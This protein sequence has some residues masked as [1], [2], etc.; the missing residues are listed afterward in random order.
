MT[1]LLETA[2]RFAAAGFSV[3]PA[4]A[5]G[6]KAPAA[7]W[8]PFQ[9]RRAAP[10][11]L[12]DWLSSGEH[13]GIGVVTG[14]VSGGLE[15]LEFEGRAVRE[16]FVQRLADAFED[17]GLGDLWRRLVNG[18]LE[19]TPSNGLHIL[20]RVDGELRGNTKLARRPARDDELT[21]QELATRER[22][23]G[24]QFARVLIE[25]RGEGGY[26]VTAPSA[27]RTHPSGGAW[28][29]LA[30]GPE[31]VAAISEDERDAVHAI[32]S[33]LD[34]MPAPVAPPAPERPSTP[35]SGPQ[36]GEGKRPGDDFNERADWREI[37]APHGWMAITSYGRGLAWRRPGKDRGISAT[38][39]T[40]EGDNLFVFSSSTEFEPETP[41][42]K[43]GAYALL[44]H[45]GD[46]AAAARELAR[47]GYG[48]PMPRED[49]DIVTLIAD[50]R[51]AVHGPFTADNPR[52][53]AVGGTEGNLATVHELEPRAR[54]QAVEEST[55]QHSD[56]RNAL[57]L[58]DRFGEQIR[59]C[60]DRGRWLVWDETRWK[61]CESGGGV[62]REF[63]RRIARSLPTESKEQARFKQ[64]SLSARGIGSAVI[65]AQTDDRVTIPIGDLDARPFDL[66]TPGGIIDLRTGE[67]RDC[68]PEGLHTR[69]AAV[70]PDFDMATPRW[71]RFLDD[72]FGGDAQMIAFVQRL[73]GYSASADVRHHILPFPHGGGQNGK[74]VLMDTL[75]H[76]L[77][78]YAT[79][80]PPGF[81]M[82]GKHEHSAEVARLQGVRLVVASEVNQNSRFDEAKLKELTGGD[83]LTARFMRQDFFTFEPTHHLWLMAN[84]KPQVRA[85]GD[86]FWRRLR[87]IPFPNRVPEDKKIEGLTEI[88]CSEE[89]PGIVAW[90]VA[91]AIDVFSGGLRE[92]ESVMAET[93]E[94]AAEE[95]QLGRFLEERCHV[96]GGDH[97]RIETRL[98]RADYEQWCHAEGEQALASSSL[99]REL[100]LR[101][102][103]QAKSNGRRFYT[104]LALLKTDEDERWDER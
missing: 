67:K 82:E 5:D 52:P 45:G 99:G 14:A 101:G 20:Y 30:G 69:L 10:E 80:A 43:F 38:T 23:P 7:F 37:L 96:G 36:R 61:W 12:A 39:G 15:M 54:L 65:L 29:L 75:G 42:S 41:Y 76:L 59:Y 1:D 74:S 97:V 17:H 27:G 103:G 91:G 62:V 94:Y 47:Q 51:P 83:P 89:G 49:D 2:R 88:L 22:Q 72:T 4:R 8:K 46:H 34:E 31:T 11:Q 40:R 16:G 58:V 86:S 24:K 44:E 85:G 28:T 6:T 25:T 73:A 77:G 19:S 13:D 100:K 55:H 53:G 104:G 98:L 50:Y 21:E 57:E 26:V 95:D 92:P 81:L 93:R 68:T 56:D 79:T 3:V 102:I 60:P 33:L 90:I 66:N 35:S 78:D 9:I 70:A 32:A 71:D 64:S 87:L 63:A 84:H 48:D 18:Y